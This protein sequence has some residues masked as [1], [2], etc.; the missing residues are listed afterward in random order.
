MVRSE[1]SWLTAASLGLLLGNAAAQ[2]TW[3]GKVYNG[4]VLQQDR[5]WIHEAIET[6][7]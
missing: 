2:D 1:L 3:C 4:Y 5:T 7:M 6:L